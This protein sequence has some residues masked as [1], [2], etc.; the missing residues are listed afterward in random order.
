[1]R[2]C[3]SSEQAGVAFQGSP[4]Q[5]NDRPIPTQPITWPAFEMKKI[6]QPKRNTPLFAVT[7]SA[8]LLLLSL[9]AA[10]A[11]KL[12]F[13]V[14]LRFGSDKIVEFPVEVTRNRNYQIDLVFVFNDPEQRVAA[15]KLAGEPAHL[16][17]P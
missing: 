3:G 16:Q 1:M 6:H 4:T 17:S 10:A 8:W 2:P 5:L 15:K 13:S 11:T 14:P 12:P 7:L 9:P